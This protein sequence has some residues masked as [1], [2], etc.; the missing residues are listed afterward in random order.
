[1][2]QRK[3]SHAKRWPSRAPPPRVWLVMMA[4]SSPVWVTRPSSTSRPWIASASRA[5]TVSSMRSDG[6]V[7]PP[8]EPTSALMTESVTFT[9]G[10]PPPPLQKPPA[11][12]APLARPPPPLLQEPHGRFRLAGR[13]R[14]VALL[15]RRLRLAHELAG[16]REPRGLDV[17][18]LRARGL[19]VLTA[20]R[21]HILGARRLN[22]LRLGG[23]ELPGRLR[24][25]GASQRLLCGGR[26][27]GE[28]RLGFGDPGRTLL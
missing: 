14:H 3:L 28:H 7:C 23:G 25:L 21:L 20:G 24:L 9:A 10:P 13:E 5:R 8:I 2:T 17:L 1:M 16:V 22:V 11:P 19:D 18:L 27:L 15:A 4:M 6:R 26:R 12:L